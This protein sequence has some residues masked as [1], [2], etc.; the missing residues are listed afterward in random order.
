MM[1]PLPTQGLLLLLLLLLRRS[2]AC[3][4]NDAIGW[5]A[6]ACTGRKVMKCNVLC[7]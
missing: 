7:S 4:P 5:A 1:P 6:G 2:G 3:P